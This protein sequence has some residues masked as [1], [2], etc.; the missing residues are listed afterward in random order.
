MRYTRGTPSPALAM[1]MLRDIDRDTV[2]FIPTYDDANLEPSVLPARYPNL[3]VNG[4]S[5]IAVGHGDEHPAAQPR[6]GDRRPPSPTST[7]RPSTWAGLMKYIKGPDFPT[8]GII[9]GW[10]RDQ[11][12]PTRPA[13]AGSSSEARAHIEPLRQGKEAIIVTELPLPGCPRATAATTAPA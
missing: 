9:V 1:E 12:T 2:D 11:G 5:G 8:G 7:T 13:V 10:A 6:R 4:S 3:L